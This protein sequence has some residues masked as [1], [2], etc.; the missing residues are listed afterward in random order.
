VVDGTGLEN[1]HTRK[2]IGGSNPSL[3]ASETLR[4]KA[5]PEQKYDKRAIKPWVTG[6]KCQV[7]RGLE[8]LYSKATEGANPCRFA[9]NVLRSLAQDLRCRMPPTNQT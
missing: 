8:T 6:V 4:L 2:G 5:A 3:S 9:R 1:R 7:T